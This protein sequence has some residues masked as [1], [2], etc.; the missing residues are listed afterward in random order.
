[1]TPEEAKHNCPRCG[2]A[3]KAVIWGN[4]FDWDYADCPECGYSGE[5]DTATGCDPDGSIWQMKREEE[6]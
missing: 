5:L 2:A 3:L 6:S 1:M 4:L